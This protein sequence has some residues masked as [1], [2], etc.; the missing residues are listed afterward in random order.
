MRYFI[1]ILI[2]VMTMLAIGCTYPP[3][4]KEELRR[5]GE[6]LCSCQGGLWYVQDTTVKCNN[7]PIFEKVNEIDVVSKGCK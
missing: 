2:L 5:R 7:G 3:A 4:S 6:I 1:A